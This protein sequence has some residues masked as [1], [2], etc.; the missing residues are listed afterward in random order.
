MAI[1]R[2]EIDNELAKLKRALAESLESA[3][4]THFV[5]DGRVLSR[6]EDLLEAQADARA[7]AL[8]GSI[9]EQTKLL[10]SVEAFDSVLEDQNAII[11]AANSRLQVRPVILQA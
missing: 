3:D 2:A 7:V 8:A 6:L 5:A 11:Q 4:N 9:P 1:S 10:S